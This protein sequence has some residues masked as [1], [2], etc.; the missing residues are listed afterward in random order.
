MAIIPADSPSRLSSSGSLPR[1][2][3][4]PIS[5]S[6]PRSEKILTDLKKAALLGIAATLILSLIEWADLNVR[7]TPVFASFSERLVFTAYLSLNLFVGSVIGLVAALLAL[8]VGFLT[9]S[10]QS[11]RASRGQTGNAYRLA[12]TTFILA[13]AGAL[14]NQEPH[15]RAYVVGLIIEAQKLPYLYGKLLP[16]AE[17]LS[18][19]IVIALVA[20][21]S[22]TW[23]VAGAVNRMRPLLGG[24][25]LIVLAAA[26]AT[27]YF[28][29][30]RYEVQLY[31]YTLHRS[32]FLLDLAL[33]MAFVRSAY[34]LSRRT[35]FGLGFIRS[36]SFRMA[37]VIAAAIFLSCV[38]F[39][40]AHFGKNQNL[41]V[42][43]LSRTTQAKQH[44]KL[45]QWAL[46]FDRDGYSAYLGGGDADDSRAGINP[47]QPEI[48]GDGLDNNSIGGDLTSQAIAEWQAGRAARHKPAGRRAQPYNIIYIFIDALRADH[49]SLYGYPRQTSPNMDKLAA[50]SSVFENAFSP[51]SNT[52]ESAARFMKSSYW[53][54]KVDSWTEVLA[55]NGYNMML[56]PQRRLSMLRRYVKGVEVAQDAEGKGL[57]D[58]VN[59]VIN[60]LGSA[61]ADNPF[62][63]YIYTVDPH[64]PYARH[65]EFDFGQ[66]NT[67]L[68]DGEIAFTDHHLGR[69]F[70]WLES[71]GRSKDTMVV[72]MADHAESLGER[73]VYRHSSE[74]YN[75]QTHVPLIFYV[76]GLPARRIATYVST[77]DLGTTVL[78]CLGMDCPQTYA[79][80]SL[81]SAIEGGPVEHPSIFGEQTLREKE[82]PNIPPEEYPQP[83]NKK[84]MVIA[85]DGYKLIYN[86]N[87]YTF[88]L[89][90]LKSD[91]KEQHN[92]YDYERAKAEGLKLELGQFIDIVLVSRPIDADE[93]KYFFGDEKPNAEE[94]G[95][96]Y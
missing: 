29:D 62:C 2:A 13:I 6:R 15:I 43:T 75:D 66:S 20:A 19:L 39:T 5:E 21:C 49:M 64:K 60:S 42:Q 82:F 44:F 35:R 74:L 83:V 26:I 25:W 41:K 77:I 40:F 56:F 71:S 87:L 95:E 47:D 14:L 22:L 84:Y 23:Y 51:S 32:M 33:S 70:D 3:Q 86:R 17:V 76:P 85:Q 38:I 16:Y 68:Y 91:P 50:R 9:K 18:Y 81:L 67:D 4:E 48:V 65:K 92:L 12:S 7:L 59:L 52:F 72:I 61:P 88:E 54:A 57:K 8:A 11:Y 94:D 53:D 27:A 96:G 28:I 79:G 37:C 90:D 69:L 34:L 93:S 78:D 36:T 58:T 55:R 63:A 73:G 89:F 1:R 80:A 31:E 45:A 10:L 30:S 46:D 24:S